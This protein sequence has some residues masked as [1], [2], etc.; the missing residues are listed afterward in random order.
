MRAQGGELGADVI[1][2]SAHEL[3]TAGDRR[4]H[5][6]L[7]LEHGRWPRERLL[8]GT[9]RAFVCGLYEVETLE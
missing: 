2:H 5:R 1:D 6:L 9:S 4:G 7:V 3:E 8:L